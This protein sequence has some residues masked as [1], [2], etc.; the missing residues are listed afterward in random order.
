MKRLWALLLAILLFMPAAFAEGEFPQMDENGFYAGGEFVY[1]NTDS[2]V[3]RY[4]S[5]TLKVEIVRHYDAG[6]NQTWY[7]AE[8]FSRD[9]DYF[10]MIPKNPDKW[11]TAGDWPYVIA[12][13][14]GTVLAVNSDY[15]SLRYQKK[16]RMGIVI[17]S[18]KVW[19]EKTHPKNE[20]NFPNLDNLALLSDGQ[21]LTF[22][23][24]EHTAE[25]YLA[26][27]ATDVLAFGPVLIRDGQLNAEGLEKYGKSKAPRAAVGMVEPGHYYAMMLEGRHN[28][29]KGAGVSFLAEKLL[30][31][32]CQ[33]GFNLDGGQT[34]TICFM[35]KQICTVGQ[36]SGTN[37][38]A[39]Q[40]SEILGIGVSQQLLAEK[41]SK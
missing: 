20:G 8:V 14:N 36:T 6:L 35:G 38:S 15:A 29:A 33:T 30:A 21:M 22:Y 3:W 12:Q 37:A 39:R 13:E 9:G 18:G 34:A 32:G 7:E 41:G 5:A 19:S 2:G 31:K 10:H 27:G 26:M 25:E 24:D 17:R 16:S 4:A 23:S 28:K 40:T 11:M 1:E